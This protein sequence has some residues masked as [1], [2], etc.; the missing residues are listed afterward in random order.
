MLD[1]GP[2][3]PRVFAQSLGVD[4]AKAVVDGLKARL[5]VSE[6]E[7]MS[8]VTLI[9]N[10]ARMARRITTLFAQGTAGFLPR[11]LLL[12]QIEQLLP[13]QARHPKRSP[14]ARRLKLAQ[15]I[16]P[17]LETRPHLAGR[18]SLF[19]IVDSLAA[20]MD[21]MQGE[22]VTPEMIAALDVS[23]ASGNWQVAQTLIGVA[24]DF[25]ANVDDGFDAEARQRAHIEALI[26]QWSNSPPDHP[27]LLAGSTGSR[28][29]TALLMK[30]LARLD[31]GAVLLPGL[32]RHMPD[33]IW[34]A[35]QDPN[36]GLAGEDHPQYRFAKLFQ[37][38]EIQA[39]SVPNWFGA[40]DQDPERQR[41]ISLAL[42][43]APVTDDWCHEGPS[44]PDLVATLDKLTLVEAKTPREEALCIAMRLRQ[45]AEDGQKAALITQD[46]LLTRQVAAALDR[47]RILPDDSAGL[48]L[49]LSAPGRFLRHTADLFC[50]RLDGEMILTLLK[51]PLTMSS[52][53]FPSHGL[54]TQWLEMWLRKARLPFP[55]A[56]D[57]LKFVEKESAA[58]ED[59]TDLT[60]WGQILADTLCNQ[61]VDT[62]LPLQEW[63][64]R[65]RHL[66][67]ALS[68][69]HGQELWAKAA[70]Q[71]AHAAFEELEQNAHH[72]DLLS[73]T[74]YAQ[75]LSRVLAQGEVRE[76]Q[77]VHPGI[78]IW[79]TLEARVQGADLVILGSLNEGSWPAALS[80]DAW[81]NRRMRVEAG[82]LL[83]ERQVGLSAHDF[84]QAVAAPEVWLTRSLTSDGNE[85]VPS[86]WLNRISNLAE[87]LPG[88]GGPK[89]FSLMRARGALWQRRATR[90]EAVVSQT[91]ERRAAP[92]PPVA[93]RPRKFS[94]T[95]IKTLIRDPYAIYA[96]HILRL[97]KLDPL[98]QQP[99]AAQRG[100]VLHDIMHDFVAQAGEDP[101]ILTPSGLL[102]IA[103]GILAADVPWHL[104]RALWRGRLSRIADW[105]VEEELKRQKNGVPVAM[106]RGAQGSLSLPQ[107]G[108]QLTARA[109]RIDRTTDGAAAIYDYKTGT[110]PTQSE[111]RIF[112]KQLLLE[113]AMVENGAF[114]DL[115]PQPVISATYI[116]LGTSPK[117]VDAPLS[118]MTAQ[119]TLTGLIE[120][121]TAYL[122]PKQHYLSRRML[123]SDRTRGDYDH[124]A[125]FGEWDDAD[126][127]ESTTLI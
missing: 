124:L 109:D 119:K 105:I 35:L 63:L 117:L 75:L 99:D 85:T 52:G 113:A 13:P 96:R 17:V 71:A 116:G 100:I 6:P 89:A 93:S 118:D 7:A 88:Q 19:D 3:T 67:E 121:L 26:A 64:Q 33:R 92:R 98:V 125:R 28:G 66:S 12:G 69:G 46:R 73:A 21:E 102:K 81:L 114:T 34:Q 25:L 77:S 10:T 38:L 39:S 107:V 29:T 58:R 90:L 91:P 120:L 41:F 16:A 43:P 108:G 30:S 110:P 1:L 112:D 65:H 11:I 27:I 83:P 32:D 70:G 48:P 24:H 104:E 84:Q 95:E 82:L 86:R 9:V 20:L 127:P 115:G 37:D 111:Q 126:P 18:R 51:H 59:Q 123:Q 61:R 68:G 50:T 49:H 5:A 106:E 47:W 40:Q 56:K 97:R 62:S 122:E 14:L 87:G 2:R 76:S 15:L 57:L 4:F 8:R 31:N 53:V 94:V 55:D 54:Y 101:T 79:G 74:D 23:D 60:A 78:M 36:T 80:L 42:R 22:A 103:D 44:L 72:A 45:A